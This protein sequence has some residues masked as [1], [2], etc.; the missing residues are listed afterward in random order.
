MPEHGELLDVPGTTR[1]ICVREADEVENQR[2]NDLVRQG[3]LLIK[4]HADK[5][6]VCT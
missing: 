2:V 6:R 4:Q 1:F 5:E 3:V